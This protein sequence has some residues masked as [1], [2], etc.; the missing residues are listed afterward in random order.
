MNLKGLLK[1]K[2]SEKEMGDFR[3]SFEIIGNIAI[4][5]IPQTLYKKRKLIAEALLRLH[6]SI[7]TVCM[8]ADER[9]GKL[10]LRK[11]IAI[12]GRKTETIHTEY[13]CKFF[14]DLK[15]TYFSPRELTERQRIASLVKKGEEVLVMFAGIGPF[16]I[17]IAKRQP[18]VKR[19]VAVELN[20]NAFDYMKK[21]IELN[22]VQDKIEAIHGDVRKICP[23][24]KNKFNRIVM[25]LPLHGHDYLDM[26]INCLKKKGIIHFYSTG[27]ESDPYSETIRLFE[28][29]CKK[30]KAKL[31]ILSKTMAL[32]YAPR[33][34]KVCVDA[35]LRK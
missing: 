15:K 24:Y 12:I 13:G 26:A 35:Q 22:K 1:E 19:I 8:K 17:Q 32:P 3:G 2:L 25:P 18:L 29:A 7:E 4:L 9:K 27:H 11:I 5:E 34:W 30:K 14:L 10:R 16:A 33:V 23:K 21:N 28:K 31:K 6:K 20:K